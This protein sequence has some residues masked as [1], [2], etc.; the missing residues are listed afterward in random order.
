MGNGLRKAESRCTLM[1]KEIRVEFLFMTL[2]GS[3]FFPRK[4]AI[5]SE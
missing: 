5:Q 1:S 3:R 4:R 2:Q